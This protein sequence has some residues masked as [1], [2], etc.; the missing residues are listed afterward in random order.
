MQVKHSHI[1]LV[2]S[3]AS[4][5]SS[6][7]EAVATTGCPLGQGQ[8]ERFNQPPMI[9]TDQQ[10]HAPTPHVEG[11]S[12]AAGPAD[13]AVC[14][15]GARSARAAGQRVL[16]TAFFDAHHRVHEQ[17]PSSRLRRG[18]APPPRLARESQAYWVFWP[19]PGE[20]VP[21]LTLEHPLGLDQRPSLRATSEAPGP[22]GAIPPT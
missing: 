17:A 7:L 2:L 1:R 8:A 11:S 6:G 9:I 14:P 21:G 20:A 13:R 4:T 3:G 19:N 5:D 16:R 15:V 12:R 18:K 22:V 10:P